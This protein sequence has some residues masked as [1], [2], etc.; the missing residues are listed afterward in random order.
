MKIKSKLYGFLAM[1]QILDT[2]IMKFKIIQM[3]S[4]ISQ[5]NSRNKKRKKINI[6]LI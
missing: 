4:P 1:V 6:P 5:V 3:L 2:S